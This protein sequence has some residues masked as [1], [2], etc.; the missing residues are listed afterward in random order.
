VHVTNCLSRPN[1]IAGAFRL[2]FDDTRPALR[3]I[4][5]VA[6][7]RSR[8]FQLPFGDQALFMRREVFLEMDGFPELPILE[9]LLLVRALKKKG[10][11]VIADAAAITSA[12]RWQQHGVFRV[13][14][15]HW[16]ILIA[17][18]LGVPPER[19]AQWRL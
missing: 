5:R 10:R 12:R 1:A 11:I 7:V 4:E 17:S 13:T 18:R 3:L 9:D 14:F 6:N 8:L 2:A 19:L 15:T 16:A